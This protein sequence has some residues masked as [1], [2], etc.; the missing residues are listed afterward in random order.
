MI[1]CKNQ[2][3][4][5]LL[6]I[7]FFVSTGIG[8]S[9][10]KHENQSEQVNKIIDTTNK[11]IYKA[12]QIPNEVSVFGENIPLSDIDVLERLD[13]ELIINNFWHSNTFFYFKR[14]NRWFPLITNILEEEG[15][16]EDFKYLAVI[17]SGLTQATSPSGAK[18]FWQFLP[19]T[20]KEYGLIINDEIDERLHVEKSTRAACK[21]LKKAY[22]I[23]DS[24]ILAAAAYNRGMNGIKRDLS[25][26]QVDSFFDLHLNT[27]TSRYVFR[28]IAAKLILSNPS[29]YG[30]QFNKDQLYPPYELKKMKIDSSI[31]N[32]VEW[33]RSHGYSKKII[34]T[35]NP[36]II[37]N[38][39]TIKTD[40][41]L[42]IHV[43]LNNKQFTVFS[44]Q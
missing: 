22:D 19:D 32:L 40:S 35:L 23:F 6:L 5:N 13:K 34:K 15:I 26:Q 41:L 36:W 14:S 10:P 31:S 38:R 11:H 20:G 9:A 2:L 24:W 28:I 33:S 44:T 27:E 7:L 39:L 12:P 21:Y 17:E 37:S 43:P 16:P 18:G 30:F 1:K 25:S 3:F 42:F 4:Y 29:E 8:C